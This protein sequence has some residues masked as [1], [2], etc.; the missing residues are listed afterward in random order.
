MSDLQNVRT[1]ERIRRGIVGVSLI[2]ISFFFVSNTLLFA[3][4]NIVAIYPLV[5]ALTGWDGMFT[6]IEY[7][8][9]RYQVVPKFLKS[10][11]PK[12]DNTAHRV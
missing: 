8:K 11:M 12:D 5:C 2:V 4:L 6:V 9:E 10:L 7:F 1:N 3:F